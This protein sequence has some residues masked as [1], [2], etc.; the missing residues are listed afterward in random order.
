MTRVGSLAS[1]E[2]GVS[3]LVRQCSE[4]AGQSIPVWGYLRHD[5]PT[6]KE[7]ENVELGHWKRLAVG[8]DCHGVGTTAQRA[9]R[10]MQGAVSKTSFLNRRLT[11]SYIAHLGGPSLLS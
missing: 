10:G 6:E 3:S 8:V 7:S 4:S 1:A 5:K 2:M 9:S 11:S